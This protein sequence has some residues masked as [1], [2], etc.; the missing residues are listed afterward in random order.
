MGEV[1]KYKQIIDFI[2]TIG[3][4]AYRNSVGGRGRYRFGIKGQCDISG[5]LNPSGRRLEIEVKNTPED[6]LSPGQIKFIKNM[7][8]KGALVLVVYSVEEVINK[9]MDMGLINNA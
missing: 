1:D 9:F 3:H 8:E 4:Y 7:Q 6:N 2:N 5:V